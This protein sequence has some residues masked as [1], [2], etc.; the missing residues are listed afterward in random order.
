MII[1]LKKDNCRRKIELG[2][3]KQKMTF[4]MNQRPAQNRNDQEKIA[5]N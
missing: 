3:N 4:Q 2:N 5:N 1:T